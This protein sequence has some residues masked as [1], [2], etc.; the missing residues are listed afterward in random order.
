[1]SPAR[2]SHYP[3]RDGKLPQGA[4]Y[5]A[6]PSRWRNEHLVQTVGRCK[7]CG[8]DHTAAEAVALYRRDLP[9]GDALATLLDPLRDAEY[10]A[11]AC[12]PGEPCHVDVLLE[13][14]EEVE[15]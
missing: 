6:R 7:L 4:R 10:L 13:L 12:K 3:R 14:L 11:C 15:R 9:T 2:L 5:V 8:A 1:M